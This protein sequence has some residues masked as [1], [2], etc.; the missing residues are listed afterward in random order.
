MIKRHVFYF[1]YFEMQLI[2]SSNAPWPDSPRSFILPGCLYRPSFSPL[3]LAARNSMVYGI[4]LIGGLERILFRICELQPN[5][6]SSSL[7]LCCCLV[8]L[9]FLCNTLNMSPA[10]S[11]HIIDRA[12][13][14]QSNNVDVVAAMELFCFAPFVSSVFSVRDLSIVKYLIA[15]F[16]LIHQ[17]NREE[18]D[19]LLGFQ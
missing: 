12:P 9:H 11:K 10:I 17:A 5:R 4:T 16:H 13:K 2:W 18:E 7:H 3:D 14:Q 6:T 1:W 15:T 19:G 8:N